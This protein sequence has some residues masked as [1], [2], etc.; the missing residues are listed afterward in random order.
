MDCSALNTRSGA[1]KTTKS[2]HDIDYRSVLDTFVQDL[3]AILYLP[4]WP[5]AA[6]FVDVLAR[7][8][9]SSMR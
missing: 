8:F 1:A 7:L 3:L 4:E 6:L 9:V 5:V 2:S